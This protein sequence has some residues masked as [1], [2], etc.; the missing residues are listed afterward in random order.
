MNGPILVF[1]AAGQ[2]GREV[3]AL[4]KARAIEAAGC[5]R[6]SA[7]ITDFASVTTAILAIKPRLVLNAAAYTAVD[8]AESEP[9]AAYAANALGAETI[10]RA[11]AL[12][13]VPVI[14]ISTDYVFDG[15]KIGAYVE[16]DPVAPLGAYGKTKAAGEVM[17]RQAN[18]RHFILRTAWVYGSYGSNFLKTILRLS[19][20]REE[21]RIVADQHGCPTAT[22]DIAEAILAIDRAVANGTEAP[23]TYHFAG[24]GVTTWH[25]FASAIVDAQAQATGRRPKVSPIATADFPTPARRPANSELDSSLFASVFGYR[26][27]D[28]QTRARET[29]EMLLKETRAAT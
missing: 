9:K 26:A 23:G 19:A 22:Q 21:L 20:E 10:A 13:Q 4:A 11:A 18:P 5:N 1:G 27:R 17:V 28:W 12:Q 6:A 24:Y 7:D 15:T 14:Q 25:G 8:K 29:V 3:M 2:L 16:T